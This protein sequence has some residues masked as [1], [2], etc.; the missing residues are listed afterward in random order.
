MSNEY[1][2]RLSLSRHDILIDMQ[3]DVLGSSRDLDLMLNVYLIFQ[4][5]HTYVSTLLDVRNMMTRELC[6]KLS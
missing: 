1:G 4:G 5:H 3:H 6:H 2:L